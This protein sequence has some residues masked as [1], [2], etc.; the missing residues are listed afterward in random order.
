MGHI[1]SVAIITFC[2]NSG[3]VLSTVH[4]QMNMAF[5]NKTLLTKTG[6]QLGFIH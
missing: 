6:V 3:K 5:T 1:F 4:K 2:Q